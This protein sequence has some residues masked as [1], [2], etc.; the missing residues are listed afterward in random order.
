M[1]VLLPLNTDA[2]VYYW[3]YATTG[4]MAL[5]ILSWAFGLSP[6]QFGLS[7]GNGLIPYQWVTS[8]LVYDG[9]LHLLGSLM[10]LWVFGLVIEGKLGWWKYLVLFFGLGMICGGLEQSAMLWRSRPADALN[11][12]HYFGSIGPSSVLYALMSISLVWAPRNSVNVLFLAYLFRL[13]AH[14]FE[15]PIVWFAVLNVIWQLVIAGM[16]NSVGFGV[17]AELLHLSG[18]GFGIAV[19][20]LFVNM[21]WVDCEG[22]DLFTL[23][24]RSQ[25]VKKTRSGGPRKKVSTYQAK[26]KRKKRTTDKTG[27]PKKTPSPDS[28]RQRGVNQI[29]RL[30]EKH[31]PNAALSEYRNLDRKLGGLNLPA[32]DL[33]AL[34][35]SLHKAGLWGEASEIFGI[36]VTSY[37]DIAHEQRLQLARILIEHERRPSAGLKQLDGL[38]L[39]ELDE[40]QQ[41]EKEALANKA[42]R[43]I[44]D[45]VIELQG[46]SWS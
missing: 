39:D 27:E 11:S 40:I 6:E 20:I 5:S 13:V 34:G 14:A 36:Y 12:E 43:M 17:A 1:F 21:K 37:P 38:S 10:F 22:W 29:R 16:L 2:P 44:D 42:Q 7:Y 33:L 45:G 23:W 15:L 32:P 31:K 9:I 35:D 46:R 26:R 19:G 3:P 4:I 28:V 18:A 8:L 25:P 41:A 24:N 30:L